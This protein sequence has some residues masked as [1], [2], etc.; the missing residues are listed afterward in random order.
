M[1]AT[2]N[3]ETNPRTP[4]SPGKNGSTQAIT[5]TAYVPAGG[6]VDLDYRWAGGGATY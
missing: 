3:P 1:P 5:R 2:S 6:S 4:T